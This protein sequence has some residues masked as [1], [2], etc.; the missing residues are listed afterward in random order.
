M[1]KFTRL[2]AFLI[3]A[4]VLLL[5]VGQSAHAQETG[6]VT[7][8]CNGA[9][10]TGAPEQVAATAAAMGC[11]STAAPATVAIG[12]AGESNTCRVTTG[13]NLRSGPGTTFAVVGSAR[14]GQILAVTAD[15]PTGGWTKLANGQWI[16]AGGCHYI[17]PSEYVAPQECHATVNAA[18]DQ[19]DWIAGERGERIDVTILNTTEDLCEDYRVIW[20]GAAIRQDRLPPEGSRV[21]FERDFQGWWTGP[22]YFAGISCKLEV[23]HDKN[24]VTPR[25]AVFDREGRTVGS[26]HGVQIFNMEAG[27]WYMAVCTGTDNP[28]FR[29]NKEPWIHP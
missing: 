17:P 28:G 27:A 20:D 22:A 1:K 4:I 26:S 8:T 12:V 18:G 3:A 15:Q 24:G 10:I 21:S 5:G 19:V 29:I 16:W 23:D 11:G 25:I 9:S 14:A 13:S 2:A 7:V 6:Q